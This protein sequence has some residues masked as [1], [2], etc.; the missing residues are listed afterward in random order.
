MKWVGATGIAGS[1]QNF[2]Q[3]GSNPRRP[4]YD[5]LV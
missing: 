5:L 3:R 4:A 2:R 1:L